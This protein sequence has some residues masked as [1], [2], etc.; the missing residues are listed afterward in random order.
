MRRGCP[1]EAAGADRSGGPV[2]RREIERL[3][4]VD[5]R[6]GGCSGPRIGVTARGGTGGCV[7]GAD[8]EKYRCC[9][10]CGK[11]GMRARSTS[12]AE[13]PRRTV[14]LKVI[15]SGRSRDHA[16]GGSRRRRTSWRGLSTWDRADLRA[17]QAGGGRAGD[18]RTSRWSCGWAAVTRVR[19]AARADGTPRD[20]SCWRAVL[21]RGA[22][23]PR[24]KRCGAPGPEPGN[25]ALVKRRGSLRCGF[26]RPRGPRDRG[27]C[28]G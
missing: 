24:Q 9:V 12:R 5:A 1:R 11:E 2:L 14:A 25:I 6:E 26:R 3:L 22:T 17:E 23:T 21:R 27:E 7:A 10:D 18:S 20:S 13:Y 28:G 16:C 19:G 15:R 4:A 8:R